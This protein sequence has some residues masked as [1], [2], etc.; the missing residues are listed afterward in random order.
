MS[1]KRCRSKDYRFLEI[2]RLHRTDL[3]YSRLRVQGENC[4]DFEFVGCNG[5]RQTG[6]DHCETRFLQLGID[7]GNYFPIPFWQKTFHQEQRHSRYWNFNRLFRPR[8]IWFGSQDLAFI[9]YYCNKRAWA[10]NQRLVHVVWAL[11]LKL[12][13]QSFFLSQ[14]KPLN[15]SKEPGPNTS[16]AGK[17]NHFLGQWIVPAKRLCEA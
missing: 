5:L 12:W 16:N 11:H 15:H 10:R 3:P 8:K 17:T 9:C 13:V 1:T 2:Q 6:L 14:F 4:S 7:R